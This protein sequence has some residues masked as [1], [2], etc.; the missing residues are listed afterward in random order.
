M[1]KLKTLV[2]A[3]AAATLAAVV[4][5]AAQAAL[6]TDTLNLTVNTGGLNGFVQGI[7]VAGQTGLRV[8]YQNT[9]SMYIRYTNGWQHFRTGT[10]D[11]FYQAADGTVTFPTDLYNDF[12]RFHMGGN[13]IQGSQPGENF[14]PIKSPDNKY[15]WLRIN[16]ESTASTSVTINDFI[17]DSDATS[18]ATAP[19]LVG[20]VVTAVPEPASAALTGLAG[21]VG[22]ARRRR[23]VR[24]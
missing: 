14:I 17:Y 5:P 16:F 21:L 9:P 23:A 13:L 10:G 12:S 2:A 15:G 22:L 7:T 11:G 3:L 20:G 24:A 4:A 19:S 18:F 8:E 1:K 6:V